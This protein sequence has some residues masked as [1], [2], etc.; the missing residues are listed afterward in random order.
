MREGMSIHLSFVLRK[1]K[2]TELHSR[3]VVRM[4]YVSKSFQSSI[5]L[6]NNGLLLLRH[7]PIIDHVFP[8]IEEPLSTDGEKLVRRI[9]EQW[10]SSEPPSSLVS[11]P[12]KRCV[13]TAEILNQQSNWFQTLT[14][15][16]L[17]GGHGAYVIDSKILGSQLSKLSER[18]RRNLFISHMKG[19]KV[20][21]M[22]SLMEGSEKI[23]DTLYPSSN[24]NFTLAV[25]HET[26][27]AALGAYLGGNPHEW[28]DHLCGIH[29]TKGDAVGKN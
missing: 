13:Q 28:P 6:P 14:Q 17:L 2:N 26:I 27:I 12:L 18:G 24:K 4:D 9:A 23:L 7:G 29:V 19:E 16:K 21:G 3:V 15:S 25:S 11:S 22:R 20:D 5:R 10:N 1:R 8:R